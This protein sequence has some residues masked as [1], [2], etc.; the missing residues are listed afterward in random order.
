[1]D[2]ASMDVERLSARAREIAR[3]EHRKLLDRTP[4]SAELY[5]LGRHLLGDLEVEVPPDR[6]EDAR[7]LAARLEVEVDDQ[8]MLTPR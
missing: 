7:S 1:M 5:Q 2:V 6:D 4:R 8:A 3:R